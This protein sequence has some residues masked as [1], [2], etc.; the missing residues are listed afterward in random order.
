MATQSRLKSPMATRSLSAGDDVLWLNPAAIE[1]KISPVADLGSSC[2][3]DWDI[4]RRFPVVETVKFRSVVQH[5]R[6]GRPWLE[7]D[8]FRETYTLRLARDG[9]VGRCRTL[10]ELADEYERRIGGLY[11]SLRD[12]GFLIETRTGKSIALPMFLQGRGG[13]IFIGNQGNHRLALAQLLGLERIAGQ[14]SCR[15][16]LAR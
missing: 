12:D 8:L 7:T 11:R 10:A 13:E 6:E 3:G 5:F 1:F 4:D 15:H 9:Y 14:I 16:T 2:G